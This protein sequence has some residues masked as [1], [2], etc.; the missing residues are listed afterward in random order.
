MLARAQEGVGFRT[1]GVVAMAIGWAGLWTLA[2]LGAGRPVVRWLVPAK[3]YDQQSIVLAAI[4]GAGV[5]TAC[6]AGLSVVGL[7]RPLPLMVLLLLWAAV[8]ALN[9]ARRPGETPRIQS[10]V[11]PLVGIAGVA[12]LVAATVSPF[13][14]Q[15]HQHL[16][17]PWI[18]LQ[19]GSI[20]PLQRNWYSFMRALVDGSG[21]G[22][23]SGL[24]DEEN[25][26]ENSC[27]VGVV[28]RR[29]YPDRPPP[30][31]NRWQ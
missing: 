1:V 12:L 27:L 9:L 28:D 13:Y 16:G 5:L 22:A 26:I 2:T 20:H 10:A 3:D 6:A 21:D 25:R 14:D 7:F 19:D 17:F 18:W 30:R 29:R 11:L 4:A 23:R 8:G 31:H 24:S 15:W